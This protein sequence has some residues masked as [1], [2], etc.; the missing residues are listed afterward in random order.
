MRGCAAHQLS[1]STAPY[2]IPVTGY[3]SGSVAYVRMETPLPAPN[4]HIV[5]FTTSQTPSSGT[6]TVFLDGIAQDPNGND[7]GITGYTITFDSVAPATTDQIAVSYFTGSMSGYYRMQT[8][9]PPTDGTT[10]AFALAHTPETGTLVVYLNGVAQDPSID[11]TPSGA[12]ISFGNPPAS[13]DKLRVS[14]VDTAV[15]LPTSVSQTGLLV[16]TPGPNG[17]NTLFS[18]SGQPGTETV[19]LNGVALRPGPGNDYQLSGSTVQLLVPPAGSDILL[20]DAYNGWS[21]EYGSVIQNYQDLI[22]GAIYGR[23]TGGVSTEYGRDALGS[24]TST[25]SGSSGS[26]ANVYRFTPYGQTLATIGTG[27]VGPYLF[28]GSGGYDQL[29]RLF[30]STSMPWRAYDQLL[31]RFISMDPAGILGGINRYQYALSSPQNFIDLQGLDPEDSRQRELDRIRKRQKLLAGAGVV[32]GRGVLE[33]GLKF[34]PP[35]L[36]PSPVVRGWQFAPEA[37][38]P[39]ADGVVAAGAFAVIALGVYAGFDWYN[40]GQTGKK[41]LFT[42]MGADAGDAIG[43]A[44]LWDPGAG[45]RTP[46]E[47]KAYWDAESGWMAINRMTGQIP[48]LQPATV[49]A[50]AFLVRPQT[51]PAEQLRLCR[52]VYAE[53]KYKQCV[54]ARCK[55][56]TNQITLGQVFKA[57]RCYSLRKWVIDNCDNNSQVSTLYKGP[58]PWGGGKGPKRGHPDSLKDALRGLCRCADKYRNSV[59]V[60]PVHAVVEAVIR[61]CKKE[62]LLP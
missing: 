47:D 48:A 26:L 46:A 7:Y 3:A 45:L 2:G 31:G 8:P 30:A 4:G 12:T 62:G 22:E 40:Y 29:Q 24:V 55:G 32:L 15:G 53:Y 6:E 25:R 21:V 17:Y 57:A 41:G 50:P 49:P 52:A 61:L 23:V 54:D 60:G 20:V 34:A 39:A 13:S 38:V 11:Y 10:M 36:E 5:T 44:Y 42:G 51:T 58:N 43:D 56:P 33:P 16:P 19:Y 1:T 14:Y 37:D 28:V 59:K 9:T 27:A 18:F 35:D